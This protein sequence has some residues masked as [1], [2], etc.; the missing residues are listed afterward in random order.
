MI[1]KE[2]MEDSASMDHRLTRATQDGKPPNFTISLPESLM[3]SN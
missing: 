3:L 1:L 2:S